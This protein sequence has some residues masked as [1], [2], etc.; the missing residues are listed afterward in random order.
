[1]KKIFISHWHGDHVGGI[2][3][4]LQT[5]SNSETKEKVMIFGPVET[6]ERLAHLLRSVSFEETGLSL[7]S[8]KSTLQALRKFMILKNTM[9]RLPTWTIRCHALVTALWKKTSGASIWQRRK[10]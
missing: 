1:V 8:G 3:G 5:M 7:M 6:Q 9:L 4:L 10:P 2:I